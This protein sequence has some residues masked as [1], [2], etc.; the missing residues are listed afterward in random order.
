MSAFT[1][2]VGVHDSFQITD[3][4]RDAERRREDDRLASNVRGLVGSAARVQASHLR[5]TAVGE[6][7]A[8]ADCAR[9]SRTSKRQGRQ[10]V[11][12][13]AP[14]DRCVDQDVERLGRQRAESRHRQPHDLLV[15]VT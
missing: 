13:E 11:D 1:I 4:E 12:A 7:I 8:Q 9:E 10:R 6:E 2:V 15:I 14:H 5:C 3:G